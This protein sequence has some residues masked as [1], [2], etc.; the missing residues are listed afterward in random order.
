ML[1]VSF[2]L[3]R[4]SLGSLQIYFSVLSIQNHL[5]H[6]Y[7]SLFIIHISLVFYSTYL[8]ENLVLFYCIVIVFKLDFEF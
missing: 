4:L 8:F 7:K 5:T 2:F 3:N 1:I 6:I